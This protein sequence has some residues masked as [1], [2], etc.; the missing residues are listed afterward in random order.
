MEGVDSAKPKLNAYENGDI[1]SFGSNS[2]RIIPENLPRRIVIALVIVL[3][4]RKQHK[5]V[6]RNF[7]LPSVEPLPEFGL[8]LKTTSFFGARFSDTYHTYRHRIPLTSLDS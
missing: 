5:L 2:N 3:R 8:A 6:K 1:A 7:T 4:F